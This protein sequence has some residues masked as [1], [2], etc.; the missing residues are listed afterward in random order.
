MSEDVEL[1]IENPP[2]LSLLTHY[3]DAAGED[4]ET[5]LDR[6]MTLEAAK[7][8][9][10]VRMHGLLLAGDWLE[11]NTGMTPVLRREG[12]PCCYR[13]TSNGRRALRR[14]KERL[15]SGDEEWSCETGSFAG[16]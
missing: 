16:V 3:A 6:I 4:R 12:V 8:E 9:E 14:V 2:L 11:Q 13:L 15:E 7:P 1:L 5:W 10:L